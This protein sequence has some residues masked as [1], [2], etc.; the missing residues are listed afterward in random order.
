L[1]KLIT[2][3]IIS[4]RSKHVS[5]KSSFVTQH[6]PL[7]SYLE[8]DTSSLTKNE[9]LMTLEKI[10]TEIPFNQIANNTIVALL[11][12]IQDP[13]SILERIIKKIANEKTKPRLKEIAISIIVKE[14]QKRYPDGNC[15][16]EQA[17]ICVCEIFTN[18]DDMFLRVDIEGN[19]LSL[20]N[21]AKHCSF[22]P[23]KN[24]LE[25]FANIESMLAA[26]KSFNATVQHIKDL[27]INTGR[28][29]TADTV[30]EAIISLEADFQASLMEQ[31]NTQALPF[32]IPSDS[33]AIKVLSKKLLQKKGTLEKTNPETDILQIQAD[34][35]ALLAFVKTPIGRIYLQNYIDSKKG[36]T[37]M[38]YI[39]D[40]LAL[41][42]PKNPKWKSL[43]DFIF[44]YIEFNLLEAK[45]KGFEK[46]ELAI[47]S[48][49]QLS[50][51]SD[52]EVRTEF[53]HLMRALFPKYTPPDKKP[54]SDILYILV[55]TVFNRSF[56]ED[57]CM[58]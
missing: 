44:K 55:N 30:D 14:L 9:S 51:K 50:L 27:N 49:E 57:I 48:Y 43:T 21:L 11:N 8:I 42:S 23:L 32:E 22:E 5:L 54:L 26:G 4:V 17:L 29:I 39:Q 40:A 12:K 19:D 16:G 18:N 24:S 37:A 1:K 46:L 33:T 6:V 47:Q 36:K 35:L 56:T 3:K 41:I 58:I 34:N 2:K 25:S 10:G 13:L 38:V 7:T 53:S 28:T 31:Y 20:K 15:N 52:H 45:S